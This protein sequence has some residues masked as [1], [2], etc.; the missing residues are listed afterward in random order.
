MQYGKIPII[1]LGFR[2]GSEFAIVEQSHINYI[3]ERLVAT[4]IKRRG[5]HS[6]RLSES[7]LRQG[8]REDNCLSFNIEEI[9]YII[10][11]KSQFLKIKDKYEE[12]LNDNS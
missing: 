4:E 11:S 12:P 9:P 6:L 10:L 5:K 1:Y 7:K 3:N 2:N 8:T